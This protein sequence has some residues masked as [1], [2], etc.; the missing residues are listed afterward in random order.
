MD[1]TSVC[2]H[3][4]GKVCKICIPRR[5]YNLVLPFRLTNQLVVIPPSNF[6]IY[7]IDLY[8]DIVSK[9]HFSIKEEFNETYV[10]NQYVLDANHLWYRNFDLLEHFCQDCKLTLSQYSC[11]WSR[12]SRRITLAVLEHKKTTQETIEEDIDYDNNS[13][14]ENLSDQEADLI[15]K[16]IL[17]KEDLGIVPKQDKK[18]NKRKLNPEEEWQ[19]EEQHRQIKRAKLDE[20]EK[21]QLPAPSK[22]LPL[23]SSLDEESSSSSNSETDESDDNYSTN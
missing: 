14:Y 11:I 23:P 17:Q 21:W 16:K 6:N 10:F 22:A 19:D 8:R 18:L 15:G 1:T 4:Y 12:R 7:R 3:N 9:F 2:I 5:N 13:Y 20:E